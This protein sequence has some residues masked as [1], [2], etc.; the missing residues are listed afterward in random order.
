MTTL[1]LR[2]S[3]IRVILTPSTPFVTLLGDILDDDVELDL[4]DEVTLRF[5]TG[6]PLA[7]EIEWVAEQADPNSVLFAIEPEDVNDVIETC[8]YLSRRVR[9]TVGNHTR[10]TGYFEIDG[11]W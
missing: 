5:E 6:D 9:L 2:P 1:G 3:W 11:E 4:S 10:G 7:P 8:Q